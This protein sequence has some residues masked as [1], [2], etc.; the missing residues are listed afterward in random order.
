MG[1]AGSD[2]LRVVRRWGLLVSFLT[3]GGLFLFLAFSPVVQVREIRVQ[4]TEARVDIERVQKSLSPLFGRHLLFLPDYEVQELLRQS[5]PDLQEVTVQKR[6]PSELIVRVQLRPILARLTIETPS[7]VPTGSGA[8]AQASGL[9]LQTGPEAVRWCFG[10]MEGDAKLPASL[11]DD[12]PNTAGFTSP[13]GDVAITA[14]RTNARVLVPTGG[15]VRLGDADAS[16]AAVR[17]DALIGLLQPAAQEISTIFAGF[18]I[19][20]PN[21][22][23]L[24]NAL[25]PEASGG[26]S[27]VYLSR[28][29]KVGG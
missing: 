2:S 22:L 17:G 25:L 15:E 16:Q 8:V 18:G 23:A 12:Y 27:E 14:G 20:A 19:S 10:P 4:R 26:A 28:K 29:V 5:I 9:V 3:L 24:A 7:D 13:G 11:T 6:Y 1:K 21:T